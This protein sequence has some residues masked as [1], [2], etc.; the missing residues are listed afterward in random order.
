MCSDLPKLRQQLKNKIP[1]EKMILSQKDK[2][3]QS[4]ENFKS[5]L[6]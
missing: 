5:K 6:I 4:F 2:E 1:E 3:L